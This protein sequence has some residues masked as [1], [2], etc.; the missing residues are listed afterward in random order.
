MENFLGTIK[1]YRYLLLLL[2]CYTFLW[3]VCRSTLEYTVTFEPN[4]GDVLSGELVQTVRIGKD[5]VYPELDNGRYELRWDNSAENIRDH[6]VI[7]AQ[8]VKVPLSEE[9]L[10]E[11]LGSAT[12]GIHSVDAQGESH[13]AAGFFLNE[14]GCVVTTFGAVA[15]MESVI[16]ELDDGDSI[17]VIGVAGYDRHRDLIVLETGLR[18]TPFLELSTGRETGIDLYGWSKQK[19]ELLTGELLMGESTYAL[20]N[21]LE[22]DIQ[23]TLNGEVLVDVYGDV[24]AVCHSVVNGQNLSVDASQ[25]WDLS[26]DEE[27]T[28]AQFQSWYSTECSRSYEV[29]DGESY[30]PAMVRTYQMIVGAECEDSILGNA[31]Y[32]GYYLR[33]DGYIYEYFEP[34]FGIYLEYLEQNGYV[35]HSEETANGEKLLRYQ[36]ELDR[37][38]LQMIIREGKSELEIRLKDLSQ[39]GE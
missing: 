18:D 1:K 25:V 11:Y 5:A 2:L 23:N 3:A 9:G 22:T 10:K 32:E 36:S 7:T 14:N 19:T 13:V 33:F 39:N 30:R 34:E 15:G 27:K 31:R 21:C 35:F 6:T 24:V 16:V 38:E 28:L 29:K 12:V 26:L 4:G 8:W 17:P 37:V 20:M